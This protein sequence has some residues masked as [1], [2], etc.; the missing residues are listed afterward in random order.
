MNTGHGTG[1]KGLHEKRH[2]TCDHDGV[3]A[4]DLPDD[5]VFAEIAVVVPIAHC[6][7]PV[8]VAAWVT[9]EHDEKCFAEVVLDGPE[10][11]CGGEGEGHGL[12]VT[13]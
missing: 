8:G 10:W 2:D 11:F 12:T 6:L 3:S 7:H 13:R 4:V 5:T 9:R 1:V